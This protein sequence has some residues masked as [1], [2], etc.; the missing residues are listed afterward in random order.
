MKQSKVERT[1]EGC[2]NGLVAGLLGSI[3]GFVI[4]YVA[5]ALKPNSAELSWI[6]WPTLLLG[7]I[8]FAYG[9]S[10]AGP[11]S[12]GDDSDPWL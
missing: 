3:I 12:G 11:A 5:A 2:M 7:I 6:L 1:G 4:G 10:M 8:G 9:F